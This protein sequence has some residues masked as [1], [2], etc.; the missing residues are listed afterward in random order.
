[1]PVQ[2]EMLCSFSTISN[3]SGRDARLNRAPRAII[4]IFLGN[5]EYGRDY[6]TLCPIAIAVGC[7][8]CPAFTICPLKSVVGDYKKPE[9]AD[10]K[11]QA[12]RANRNQ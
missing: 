12:D 4:H 10:P 6:M 5:A 2:E 8:K 1:M 11:Q 3:S 7:K 9:G